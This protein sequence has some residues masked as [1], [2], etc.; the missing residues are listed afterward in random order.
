MAHNKMKNSIVNPLWAYQTGLGPPGNVEFGTE[1]YSA[2]LRHKLA[3]N[4]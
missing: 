3:I 2:K 4:S 1:Y